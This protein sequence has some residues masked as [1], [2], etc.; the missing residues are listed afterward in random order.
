MLNLLVVCVREEEGQCVKYPH[1]SEMDILC[2]DI[3]DSTVYIEFGFQT[4]IV[5][6]RMLIITVSSINFGIW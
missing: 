6:N 3:L 4:I 5:A 2:V 1:T